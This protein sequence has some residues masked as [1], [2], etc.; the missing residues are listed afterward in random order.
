MDDNLNVRSA[1]FIKIAKPAE[2]GGSPARSVRRNHAATP[3]LHRGLPQSVALQAGRECRVFHG[4]GGQ[5][6]LQDRNESGG[7]TGTNHQR[8]RGVISGGSDKE[9]GV[10]WGAD[11]RRIGSHALDQTCL[12]S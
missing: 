6:R 4:Q 5:Q 3:Q 10:L 7:Q 9:C 12:Q 8:D 11:G 2:P 1:L